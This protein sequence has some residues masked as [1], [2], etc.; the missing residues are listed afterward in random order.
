MMFARTLNTRMTDHGL[1][2][3]NAVKSTT[4][5]EKA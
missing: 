4:T 5:E 3:A 2:S 1:K